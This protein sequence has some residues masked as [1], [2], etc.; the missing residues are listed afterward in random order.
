MRRAFSPESRSAKE[1][2]RTR[3]TAVQV[4]SRLSRTTPSSPRG[5]GTARMVQSRSTGGKRGLLGDD[6]GL[7]AAA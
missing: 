7:A 2:P 5:T 3:S 4:P 6:A 1:E